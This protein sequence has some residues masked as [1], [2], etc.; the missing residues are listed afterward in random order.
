MLSLYI[1]IK[2]CKIIDFDL[3]Q[4]IKVANLHSIEELSNSF[5]Y[6]DLYCVGKIMC[7]LLSTT[8]KKISI[9]NG[10]SLLIPYGLDI[11]IPLSKDVSIEKHSLSISNCV[12]V[13]L[14]NDVYIIK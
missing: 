11:T 13:S 8:Q 14:M 10:T 5:L 9:C 4:D 12:S 1:M 2:T 6:E 7:L 3:S